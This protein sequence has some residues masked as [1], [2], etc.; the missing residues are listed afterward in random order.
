MQIGQIISEKRPWNEYSHS[1]QVSSAEIAAQS[2][3]NG[4]CP[5]PVKAKTKKPAFNDWPTRAFQPS[6]FKN[7]CSVGL[8]TG[9]GLIGL[10]IDHYDPIVVQQVR[11]EAEKCFG[12]GL[13]RIGQP[14]KILLLYRCDFITK[15]QT[16]KL[17]PSGKAPEG[18]S[19]ALEILAKGQQAVVSGIHPETNAPYIWETV[20]PWDIAAGQLDR[21][22]Q[23]RENEWTA[24][25]AHVQ[26]TFGQ[27]LKTTSKHDIKQSLNL[28]SS[29][30]EHRAE[31]FHSNHET[32]LEE[33]TEILS[34][35]DPSCDYDTWLAVTMG[36]KSLGE[37]FYGTWLSWSSQG[38]NHEPNVDP[39][40][41]YEVSTVGGISL[42]TVCQ[43]VREGGADLSEI[44]KKHKS[45]ITRKI[46]LTLK[47]MRCRAELLKN[48]WQLPAQFPKTTSKV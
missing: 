29:G 36:V 5:I 34:Y 47:M 26:E 35:I 33:A 21:L 17:A 42:G 24:F 19:E 41:W 14:P 6:D 48:Y 37:Q 32:S 30:D 12:V 16:L 8:K 22:P 20:E 18:K 9:N 1:Q 38:T 31:N 46:N 7:S 25:L 43:M 10:D 27:T 2:V 11:N 13:A 28:N 3:G 4:F 23:I 45:K 44:A 15:K 39:R 40:K